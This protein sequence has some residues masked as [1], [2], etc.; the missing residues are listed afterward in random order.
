MPE[1]AAAESATPFLFWTTIECTTP[2][3]F[4]VSSLATVVWGH[5]LG[6]CVEHDCHGNLL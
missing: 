6:L 2:Q 3:N 4:L 5:S 1:D